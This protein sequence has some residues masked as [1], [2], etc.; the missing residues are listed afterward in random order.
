MESERE[1]MTTVE[2]RL[3]NMRTEANDL[4]IQLAEKCVELKANRE[5]LERRDMD[6]TEY[7]ERAHRAE[8][9][10]AAATQQAAE[11]TQQDG[12]K[13]GEKAQLEKTIAG[14]LHDQEKVRDRL[15]ETEGQLRLA[16]ETP[17]VGD[18]STNDE[19][20]AKLRAQNTQLKSKNAQ[21][22]KGVSAARIKLKGT[23]KEKS[24]LLRKLRDAG[25]DSPR[26]AT[27][28]PALSE[29]SSPQ[30]STM[31]TESTHDTTLLQTQLKDKDE[32]VRT[33]TLEAATLSKSLQAARDR[34]NLQLKQLK[35]SMAAG[36]GAAEFGPLYAEV[37]SLTQQLNQAERRIQEAKKDHADEI[38]VYK[39]AIH[40]YYSWSE[41]LQAYAERIAHEVDRLGGTP[42]AM[43]PQPFDTPTELE[44]EGVDDDDDDTDDDTEEE[45]SKN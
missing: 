6:I 1:G 20:I 37:K 44:S 34:F 27:S 24:H 43:P 23:E 41:T 8:E 22:A 17:V 35:D 14:L 32:Q 25:L 4:Q 9:A 2:Q 5:N 19:L 45:E 38:H 40:M 29:R 21:H 36:E 15:T 18:T 28:S 11:L 26:S 7:Q 3:S 31:S 10:A 42:E 39:D 13:T 16:R 33:L 12:I 30:Q